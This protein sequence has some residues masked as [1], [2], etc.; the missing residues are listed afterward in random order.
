MKYFQ[1]DRLPQSY[2]QTFPLSLHI[3]NQLLVFGRR[4]GSWL[5]LD[6]GVSSPGWSSG[7]GHRV[8]FLGKTLYSHSAS[9]HPGV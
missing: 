7:R 4:G 8:V 1:V 9:L 3:C 6:S 5:A 2:K